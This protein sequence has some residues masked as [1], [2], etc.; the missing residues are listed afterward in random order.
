MRGLFSHSDLQVIKFSNDSEAW[1]YVYDP[2]TGEQ[3]Y[4]ATEEELRRWI[5]TR[6]LRK[7]IY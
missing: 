7:L 3:F 1:W 6:H 4:A 2:Q 5:K